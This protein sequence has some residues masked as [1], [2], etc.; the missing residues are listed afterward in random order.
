[1]VS[2][3]KDR[4][5]IWKDFPTF[6]THGT[7]YRTVK[8]MIPYSTDELDKLPSKHHARTNPNLLVERSTVEEVGTFLGEQSST[9]DRISLF[10]GE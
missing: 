9:E 4:G 3:L 1:M 8:Q 10:L 2:M 5:I 7:H 6:F